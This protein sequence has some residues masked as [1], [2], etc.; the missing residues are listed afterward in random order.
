MKF[1]ASPELQSSYK[2]D[3]VGMPDKVT[4]GVHDRMHVRDIETLNIN[5]AKQLA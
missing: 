5:V 1:V 3:L 2:N 4:C